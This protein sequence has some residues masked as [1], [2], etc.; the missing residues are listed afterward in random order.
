MQSFLAQ[1]EKKLACG[2]V[3]LGIP[4]TSVPSIHCFGN[5]EIALITRAGSCIPFF[6]R[7]FQEKEPEWEKMQRDLREAVDCRE[8]GAGAG[9]ESSLSMSESQKSRKSLEVLGVGGSCPSSQNMSN[10]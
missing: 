8:V 5:S 3:C 1:A 2:C 4:H 7:V 9:A 6:F 10:T